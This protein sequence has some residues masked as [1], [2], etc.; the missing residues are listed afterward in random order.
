MQQYVIKILSNCT[1]GMY[2]IEYILGIG[3]RFGIK[4]N[5]IFNVFVNQQKVQI[6]FP[7]KG[8]DKF[9][10]KY[11]FLVLPGPQNDTPQS[12]Y[13]SKIMSLF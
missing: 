9:K 3:H 4:I 2:H 10:A 1:W 6:W 8:L 11:P 12:L 5:K 13:L 7:S